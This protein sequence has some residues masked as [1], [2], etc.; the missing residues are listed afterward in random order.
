MVVAV[1][2]SPTPAG[3]AAVRAGWEWARTHGTTVVVL[4]VQ[5]TGSGDTRGTEAADSGV[6][7]TERHV[8]E[9]ADQE[10]ES[11]PAW[12]VAATASGGD[13]ASALL[14]LVQE[15]GAELLVLGSKRRSAVGKL[16]MG[17]TV[18]RALLDSPVPV[19][20]VKAG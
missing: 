8:S 2:H 20:V 5:E 3:S 14:D 4:H 7:E 11:V 18:Q 1:A 16:L 10:Q 15:H 9:L 19:L 17:S 13:V 12:R 6:R